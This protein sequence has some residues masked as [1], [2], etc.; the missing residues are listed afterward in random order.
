QCGNSSS[1][2]VQTIQE[3]TDLEASASVTSVSCHGGHDGIGTV[4]VAGG[5]APYAVD[6]GGYNPAALSAGTYAIQVTDANLCQANLSVFVSQPAPFEVALTATTP[7]CTNPFSGTLSPTF[8]GGVDPISLDWGG[9]DPAAAAAGEYTLVAT[10]DAGCTAS[11]SVVVLEADIPEPLVLNGDDVVTQGDSA[12][13]YY[14]FTLGSNYAW[15]FTGAQAQQV[16][17]S[18]AI[19]LQWD[20]L[21]MHQVCVTETNEGG[22]VGPEVCLE[23]WVEDDVA[24]VQQVPVAPALAAYPNPVQHTLTV[25]CEMCDAGDEV[26][27]WNNLGA[28]V[29][30]FT[31]ED[32]RTQPLD[33][34]PLSAGLHLLQVGASTTPFIVK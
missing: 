33:V 12:A 31:W 4:D 2:F 34:T 24:S 7:L 10:D 29:R 15:T 21:G 19:S 20:S 27:V 6:W 30:T 11:A 9:V 25:Q 5:V 23:V 1:T 13:Y 28:L 18:F 14:E 16:F 26:Q 8:T 3:A 17:N 22:C 32:T